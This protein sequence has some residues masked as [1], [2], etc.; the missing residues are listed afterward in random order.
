MMYESTTPHD[1]PKIVGK[2]SSEDDASCLPL[3]AKN[4]QFEF[5]EVAMKQHETRVQHREEKSGDDSPWNMLS[6][7]LGGADEN[8][9]TDLN[10]LYRDELEN[11]RVRPIQKEHPKKSELETFMR[12]LSE[13]STDDL[14]AFVD[15]NSTG[16]NGL[17]RVNKAKVGS[18]VA[19]AAIGD[20]SEEAASRSRTR[21]TVTA[22]SDSDGLDPDHHLPQQVENES[23]SH[24]FGANQQ[25]ELHNAN[26]YT[27]SS[28]PQHRKGKT[29]STSKSKN[30]S[31]KTQ[32]KLLAKTV[33]KKE[34]EQVRSS[35]FASLFSDRSSSNQDLNDVYRHEML[36][37]KVRSSKVR[38]SDPHLSL[39]I[40]IQDSSIG[41][42]AQYGNKD[43]E[44]DRVEVAPD[45]YFLGTATT[46]TEVSPVP[47]PPT[48][49]G[50]FSGVFFRPSY[51]GSHEDDA[52]EA[53]QNKDLDESP[54]SEFILHLVS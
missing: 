35:F 18:D 31:V 21:N 4:P 53:L 36:M 50:L 27:H 41:A 44:N 3:P 6:T 2:S 43:E 34:Q 39:S 52:A 45:T 5:L 15:E 7:F 40:K 46:G 47:A 16:L 32:S 17:L 11:G 9:N 48:P 54:D 49:D 24:R 23:E 8:A 29:M 1:D 26:I 33:E 12:K 30:P 20:A 14:E 37:R 28:E 25:L 13:L 42:D 22:E 51:V 10:Q 19:S 38:S